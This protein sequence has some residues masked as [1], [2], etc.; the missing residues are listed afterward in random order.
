MKVTMFPHA[1]LKD[2]ARAMSHVESQA[3][4]GTSQEQVRGAVI[5]DIA[6]ESGVLAPILFM[7]FF[8]AFQFLLFNQT[9]PTPMDFTAQE[10][11]TVVM[12]T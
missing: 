6:R 2:T 11:N 9:F 7:P 5:W 12:R 3:S 10:S 4:R 1:A 8:L